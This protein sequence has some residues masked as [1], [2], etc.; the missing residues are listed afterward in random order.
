[1]KNNSGNKHAN[2]LFP[3]RIQMYIQH[4]VVY[5]GPTREAHTLPRDELLNSLFTH[6]KDKIYFE[7]INGG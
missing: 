6:F 4:L 5:V 1:M 7:F 2:L 3:N